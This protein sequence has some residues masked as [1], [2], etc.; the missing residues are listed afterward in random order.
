MALVCDVAC[1]V[2]KIHEGVL[3][4]RYTLSSVLCLE[5]RRVVGLRSVVD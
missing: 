3:Y 4:E 5:T 2:D 1:E